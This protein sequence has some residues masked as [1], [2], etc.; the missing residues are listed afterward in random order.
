MFQYLNDV[1]GSKVEIGQIS[2][3]TLQI[4]D[5]LLSSTNN[6]L[7]TQAVSADFQMKVDPSNDKWGIYFF[8]KHFIVLCST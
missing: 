6:S 7:N 8:H 3:V 4:L 1:P 5:V 2:E